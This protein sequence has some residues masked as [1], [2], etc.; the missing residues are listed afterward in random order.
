MAETSFAV[1][2]DGPAI[3]DGRMPVRDL[4]PA[5]LALGELFASAGAVVYPDRPPLDL[6]IEA[7]QEGSFLIQLVLEATGYGWDQLST[8]AN[9]NSGIAVLFLKEIIIDGRSGLFWLIKRLKGKTIVEQSLPDHEGRI[10]LKVDD[11]TT[12][13]V[14]SETL[15]LFRNVTVRKQ[16]RRVIEPVKR[17]G[18]DTFEI[19]E[20]AEVSVEIGKSDTLAFDVPELEAVELLDEESELVLQIAA[21][22]L[23]GDTKWRLTDGDSSFTAQM[24]DED[25][26][27]TI[28]EGAAFRKG[29]SLRCVIRTVQSQAGEKLRTER[30]I[31]RVIR[32]LPRPTQLPLGGETTDE[33]NE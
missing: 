26:L 22:V 14:R 20:D 27:R 25:F 13:T 17:E 31:V 6:N 24:E 3:T 29:D 21:P 18:I 32:H 30:H 4:A 1:A 12:L 8:F 10:T 28:E 33:P 11:D 5:L 15:E 16:A 19:R 9:S 2:Y 7:T 23:V